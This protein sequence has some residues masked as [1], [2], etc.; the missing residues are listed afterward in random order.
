MLQLHIFTSSLV[1]KV[2][3]LHTC[4]S[5]RYLRKQPTMFS[6]PTCLDVHVSS[7]KFQTE[8]IIC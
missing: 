7:N 6:D 8:A 1:D 3:I 5:I 4:E 2:K